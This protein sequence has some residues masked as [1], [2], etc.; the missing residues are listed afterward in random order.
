MKKF[1]FI[2]F[3]TILTCFVTGGLVAGGTLHGTNL[4]KSQVVELNQVQAEKQYIASENKIPQKIVIS[5]AG[6]VLLASGVGHAIALH[7]SD[8]PW[9]ETS[10]LLRNSDIA[11]AN[12]ECPVGRGGNSEPNKEFTFRAAPET[13]SGAV[14]AGVDIF[15][16]ANNHVLDFGRAAF[17]ET[18][19][20]LEIN[21]IKYTGAGISV[22]EAWRPALVESNGYKV[23]VLAFSRVIPG[24]HWVAGK[25]WP[26][27]AD[28]F[29]LKMI[30]GNI[31]DAERV[32]DETIVSV[33]WGNELDDFPD[34]RE[35]DLAHMMV[36]AGADIVI[37]HHPHVLQGIEIYRG[38]IIAYSLGNF[39][40][41]PGSPKA[42]EGA[43]LQVISNGEGG[44]SAS[45]IPTF[46]GDG[47]TMLL[48]GAGR[49]RVLDKMNRLS[50]PFGVFVNE[51]GRV[52]TDKKDGGL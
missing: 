22:E 21:G 32:A 50:V 33:H 47:S 15:T 5:M 30:A 9:R 26:G 2:K 49:K 3:L 14:N 45:I 29:D 13:L 18:L 4:K 27:V 35:I 37:G 51:E 12:L 8:Y 52:M 19:L 17:A 31:K 34:Q 10:E 41:T 23:A 7:G 39:I 20:N 36:E 16:L 48:D 28:G 42:R 1:L 6:D 44:Y 46:I 25:N 40:F 43:I 38:K 24:G 11:I